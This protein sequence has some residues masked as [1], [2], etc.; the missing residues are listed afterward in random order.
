MAPAIS[1]LACCA[2]YV[3]CCAKGQA[4]LSCKGVQCPQILQCQCECSKV[5]TPGCHQGFKTPRPYDELDLDKAIA[6]RHEMQ[7]WVAQHSL[8][9]N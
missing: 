4:C 1:R 5:S 6:K 7:N 2:C 8:S 9:P 3:S